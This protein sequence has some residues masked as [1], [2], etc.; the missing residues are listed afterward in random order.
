MNN[1]LKSVSLKDLQLFNNHEH[2]GQP[3]F[4]G[5]EIK[6]NIW[7]HILGS[8]LDT[9][10]GEIWKPLS[11]CTSSFFFFCFSFWIAPS[12]SNNIFLTM[13]PFELKAV[14]LMKILLLRQIAFLKV[15]GCFFIFC[16]EG[17]WEMKIYRGIFKTQE[18]GRVHKNFP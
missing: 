3:N 14:N 8:R 12:L 7:F 6:F 10:V 16:Y 17:Y 2:G 18:K 9:N 1:F 5:P 11:A 4:S 15:S 13:Q